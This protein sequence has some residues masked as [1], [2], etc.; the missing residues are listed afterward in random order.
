MLLWL[1]LKRKETNTSTNVLRLASPQRYNCW[2]G[3]VC[4]LIFP[5]L[6]D[7]DRHTSDSHLNE[8]SRQGEG[9]TERRQHREKK[10]AGSVHSVCRVICSGECLVFVLRRKIQQRLDRRVNVVCPQMLPFLLFKYKRK[11]HTISIRY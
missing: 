4:L 3:Q 11:C 9:T 8:S 10:K 1:F 2:K 6:R 7:F 5:H